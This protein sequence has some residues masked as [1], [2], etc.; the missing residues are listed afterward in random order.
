MNTS[1]DTRRPSLLRTGQRPMILTAR[2]LRTRI[3]PF[4][5]QSIFSDFR[6][7]LRP[8]HPTLL[9]PR[10]IT[11]SPP[12]MRRRRT[13]SVLNALSRICPRPFDPESH[14]TTSTQQCRALRCSL[15]KAHRFSRGGIQFMF[16][17]SRLV[18]FLLVTLLCAAAASAQQ[19]SPQA[20]A[21]NGKIHL[22]VVVAPKSGPPVGDLQ[23][24]DF[25]L[26]DN[27]SPQAIA[28]FQAVTGR[29]APVEVVL[30]ID[31]INVDASAL[32]Y[33]RIQVDKFLR[34]EGGRLAYPV[35][36][37]VAT[38]TGVKLSE[39]FSS[40]CNALA[41]RWIAIRLVSATS[42]APP[43]STAQ[44]N[45]CSI[46][47]RGWIN[48]LPPRLLVRGAKSWSGFLPAGLSFPAPMSSSPPSS[49]QTSSR[50]L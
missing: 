5:H 7:C 6:P 16:T 12:A 25:T 11:N 19:A 48:L 13:H 38:D 32:G 18:G 10:L 33:E 44:P 46:P 31:A 1:N 35:A 42:D 40:D 34:A 17:N 28:S 2:R 49:K 23:Q 3:L 39:N 21:A 36:I 27:G 4:A 24:Q 43:A 29:Q 9:S 50:K 15:A 30:V 20:Q 26:L 47:S 41:P 22:D 14:P 8:A 45:A 37:A